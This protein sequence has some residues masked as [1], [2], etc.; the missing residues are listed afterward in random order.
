[1]VNIKSKLGLKQKKQRQTPENRKQFGVIERHA[2]YK[3]RAE[4]YKTNRKTQQELIKAAENKNPDEYT[5]QMENYQQGG[6]LGI[7]EIRDPLSHANDAIPLC[8]LVSSLK[9]TQRQ[10]EQLKGE[11]YDVYKQKDEEVDNMLT[12]LQAKVTSLETEIQRRD[13]VKTKRGNRK[14]TEVYDEKLDKNVLKVK[15][16]RRK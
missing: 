10:I 7:K 5:F 15:S 11:L 2:E 3:L 16:E 4:N 9:K 1:M 14:V 13:V 12:E 6:I 8:K